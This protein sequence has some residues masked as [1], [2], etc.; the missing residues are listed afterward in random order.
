MV[1]PALVIEFGSGVSTIAIAEALRVS[2]GCLISIDESM[3]WSENTRRLLSDPARVVFIWAPAI[4]G[5]DYT[6]LAKVFSP[7]DKPELVIVDGPSVASRFSEPALRLYSELL[8]SQ[9]ICAIDDT[10]REQ[11][12]KAASQLAARFSLRKVDYGDPIYIHHK[13]SMLFPSD[14][15]DGILLA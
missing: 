2:E 1:K 13:Y 9:S 15:S 11:N 12:D 5:F 10:D 6:L 4:G 3:N 7:K 8:S 14:L